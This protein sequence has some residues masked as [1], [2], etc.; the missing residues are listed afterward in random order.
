MKRNKLRLQDFDKVLTIVIRL[1]VALAALVD[2][3][4]RL[5]H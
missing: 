4:T 1:I 3:V 5:H 2:A